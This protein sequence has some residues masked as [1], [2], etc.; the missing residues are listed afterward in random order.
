[1]QWNI[2][3]YN[4]SYN[5]NSFLLKEFQEMFFKNNSLHKYFQVTDET[6]PKEVKVS[7]FDVK[8]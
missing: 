4:A 8:S 7:V 2:I 6:F 1:M 3:I 5:A